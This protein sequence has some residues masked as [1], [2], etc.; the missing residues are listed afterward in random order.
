MK[1]LCFVVMICC[2]NMF[3]FSEIFDVNPVAV[4]LI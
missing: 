4:N 3:V 2:V 1:L